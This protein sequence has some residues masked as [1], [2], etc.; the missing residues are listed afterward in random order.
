MKKLNV[1]LIFKSV[2]TSSIYV[3]EN[4]SLED[5]IQY[6]KD[7]INEIHTPSDAEYISDSDEIDEE[8]C[9]FETDDKDNYWSNN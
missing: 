5:A 6:A 2:G 4:L 9:D 3:P 8:C 1:T 7:H